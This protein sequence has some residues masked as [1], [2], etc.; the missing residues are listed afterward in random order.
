[1]V[2]PESGTMSEILVKLLHLHLV[3]NDFWNKKIRAK[4]DKLDK[5]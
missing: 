1:M 2:D 3:A 5:V 4:H